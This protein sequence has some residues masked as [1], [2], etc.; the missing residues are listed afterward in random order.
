MV[1][2]R[3]VVRCQPGKAGHVADLLRA[4]VAPS[5]DVDGVV[6]FNIAQD[7]IDPDVFVATEVYADR[8]ALDRQMELPE[9]VTALR[10]LRDDASLLVEREANLYDA[11]AIEW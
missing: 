5:R 7:L 2:V 3:F 8:A 10:A 11:S 1:V 9:V 4:V 6:R